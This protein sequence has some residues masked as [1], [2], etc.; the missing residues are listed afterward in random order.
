MSDEFDPVE[1]LFNDS[2]ET[3]KADGMSGDEL[4]NAVYTLTARR[5]IEWLQS[6]GCTPGVLQCALRFMKDNNIQGLP[7]EGGAVD[8][9][10][11]RLGDS[12]PFPPKTGTDA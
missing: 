5:L 4:D 2:L 10:R 3:C 1:K 9:L 11:E 6:P 8:E 7:V 12:L